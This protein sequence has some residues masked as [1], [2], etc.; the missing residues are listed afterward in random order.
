MV[1]SRPICIIAP[2]SA[3]R[4]SDNLYLAE[5]GGTHID[6]PIHFAVANDYQ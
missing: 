1:R 5:H 2:A 4:S 6:A 3:A